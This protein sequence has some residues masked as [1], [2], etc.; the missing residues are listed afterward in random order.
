MKSKFQIN[1]IVKVVS[2]SG[3]D[4]SLSEAIGLKGNIVAISD[5]EGEEYY[6]VYLS[7]KEECWFL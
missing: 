2:V 3:D 4:P 1:K 6:S 5:E 7:E